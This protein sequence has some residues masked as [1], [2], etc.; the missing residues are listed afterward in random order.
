M[1]IVGFDFAM[2][3]M[4]LVILLEQLLKGVENLPSALIG[5]I[6]SV[7]ALIIFGK[8]SFIIPAMLLMLLA[9]SVGRRPIEGLWE[10]ASLQEAEGGD[11]L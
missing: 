9:L 8:E 6:S 4:F 10:R 11:A 3:A 1:N 5:I 2:T 7:I